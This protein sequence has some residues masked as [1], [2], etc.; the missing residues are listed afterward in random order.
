MYFT[1]KNTE[2]YSLVTV[3]GMEKENTCQFLYPHLKTSQIVTSS[4]AC[5]SSLE[6]PN[7]VEQRARLQ[8]RKIGCG[9]HLE[10]SIRNNRSRQGKLFIF[11]PMQR[12]VVCT[13]E[14]GFVRIALF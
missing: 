11:V 10:G 3:E 12:R 13:V 7:N 9:T 1:D 4:A 2:R 6:Q 5:L 14:L 8:T